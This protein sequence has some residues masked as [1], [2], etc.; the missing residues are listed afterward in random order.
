VGFVEG[1]DEVAEDILKWVRSSSCIHEAVTVLQL[2][3]LSWW[4]I[5]ILLAGEAAHSALNGK[6]IS[7]G[8]DGSLNFQ[9]VMSLSSTLIVV[10]NTMLNLSITGIVS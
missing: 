1:E 6:T 7:E 10:S 5:V 2:V 9:W 8:I 4:N 3:C